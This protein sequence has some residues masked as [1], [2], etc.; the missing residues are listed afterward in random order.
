M[1][2][3]SPCT[4]FTRSPYTMTI[5]YRDHKQH[6]ECHIEKV[7]G[8]YLLPL[9]NSIAVLFIF[10]LAFAVFI[11]GFQNALYFVIFG[12]DCRRSLH[13]NFRFTESPFEPF[14]FQILCSGFFLEALKHLLGLFQTHV[15]P[16][17]LSMSSFPSLQRR[18]NEIIFY[19][20]HILR[21]P[22]SWVQRYRRRCR[23]ANVTCN[24][25]MER[26]L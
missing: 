8:C 26:N 3:F 22:W 25:R 16:Q 7:F 6:T 4:Y 24:N 17:T 14:Q 11:F 20:T 18:F 10:I 5:N 9:S 2:T 23:N 12:V 15:L 19:Y 13:H 21:L 1:L